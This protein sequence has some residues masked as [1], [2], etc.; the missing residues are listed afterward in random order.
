MESRVR[1]R[2]SLI[3]LAC[4][5]FAPGV[6]RND[7][8]RERSC[9]LVAQ[10][11]DAG[12]RLCIL[13]ELS[14]SGYVFNRRD[15]A[16][17]LA[18]EIPGSETVR[19]W[20][21]IAR[22]RAV[23]IVA[24]A[25]EREG[26]TLYN[27]AVLVGPGGYIGTYRKMHL[28]YEEKLFFEPG[29]HGL[30]VF[31]TTIGRIGICICYDLW[32]PETVRLLALQGADVVCIPTNWVP[33]PG[34]K[35]EGPPMAIYLCMAA[36]HSNSVFVAA[37]DRVG[38]ER[39]QPFLGNSVVVGPDG[40]PIAG[41]AGPAADEILY[42]ECNLVEARRAKS[43]SDLNDTLRDRRTDFYDITLGANVKPHAF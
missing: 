23:F 11:A 29:N 40:W 5:Q 41:P 25:A 14:N 32:F 13:P 22:E 42:A 30:P 9:A 35:T 16:L 36:A 12:A 10:A 19:A 4:L 2:E 31:P 39:G 28:W 33:V 3:K 26:G 7:E 18:E 20:E 15:E 1:G 38:E 34:A 17:E 21:A 27:S 37:A 43:W 24:G 8:N 6:G